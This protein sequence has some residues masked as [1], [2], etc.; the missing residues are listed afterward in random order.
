[1]SSTILPLSVS[2]QLTS[3]SRGMK[4]RCIWKLTARARV[5]RS[6]V[7]AAFSRRLVRYSPAHALGRLMLVAVAAAAVVDEDL[8]VHLGLAAQLVDVALEL[9]L[10][11][12]NGLAQALVVVED[13]S[14]AE[15]QDGGV[16]K[17]VGDDPGVID[18]G[19]LVQGFSGVVFA[20]DDGQV[21]GGIKKNLVAADSEDRFQR[22]GF[23]MTG[24]FRKCLFFTDAVGVPCHDETLRLRAPGSA[25]RW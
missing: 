21:T 20:D 16:L 10:V 4:S 24:Q 1:M 5:W 17:T 13:G 14:K 7:R 12:A 23:A 3:S 22:N 19:L 11:G 8:Q 2:R 6:R 9:A 15:R 18:A 25:A